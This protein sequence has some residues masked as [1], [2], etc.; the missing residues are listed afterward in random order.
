[1]TA[2]FG[3]VPRVVAAASVV[4]LATATLTLAATSTPSTPPAPAVTAAA[5]PQPLVVPDVRKQAYVFAKGSLEQ[6]GFAWK[7]EG[8]VQGFA[9]NVVAA[10]TPAPGTKVVPN[11]APVVVLRLERNKGYEEE[12]LPENASPYPGTPLRLA[13]APKPKPVAR[14]AASEPKPVNA[15]KKAAAAPKAKKVA[16]TQP[17]KPDFV[18]PGAPAEPQDEIAL[19][20]RAR[21]L[22]A[23]LERNPKPSDATVNHWLYQ[24]NWIV[25]GALYGWSGGAEALRTLV[26]V[27]ARVQELWGIGGRSEELARRTL[28]EVEARSQ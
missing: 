14:P 7:V 26:A 16:K 10:Q 8:A 17:R 22:A 20:E 18:V 4:L 24:H 28:A 21:Q 25:T 27:D 23:W 3:R 11:G 2:V 19:P 12:G 1:M 15:P 5:E 9:A 6:A 13:D